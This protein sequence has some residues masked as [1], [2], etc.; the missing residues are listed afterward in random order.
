VRKSF[1]ILTL[2]SFISVLFIDGC[3]PSK[4]V[5][6]ERII[7]A[8]R[9]IKRLEANRRKI[10]T[11]SGYGS[12]SIKTAD[13]DAKSTFQVEIK[14]PDS[15]K[16]SFFGPFGIDLATAII[17]QKD[18]QFYDAINNNYYK[19]KMRSEA[20]KQ[21][22]KINISFEELMDVLTGSV[23]MT[24]K[25]RNEP[26]IY[27]SQE[28]FYK[29]TYNDSSASKASVYLIRQ[30]DLGITEYSVNDF[31]GKNMLSASYSDFRDIEE[32]PIPYIIN[33]IEILNNQKIKL[34]YR[35]I[36]VN[37]E[38][39]NLNIDIPNDAKIIEW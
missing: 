17:T 28:D 25:L 15:V 5:Q 24:D 7:S 12:I 11:F 10:K 21:V 2:I 16:V 4:P 38:I 9:L 19:G 22:M 20:M 30:K 32:T 34:E 31:K 13:I 35:S 36:D 29:L 27:E 23:N 18:F 6:Q 39:G 33:V 37:K 8:D 26:N 14:R 3:I 1:L